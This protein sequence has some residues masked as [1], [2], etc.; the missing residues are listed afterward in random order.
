MEKHPERKISETGVMRADGSVTPFNAG[1]AVAAVV[2]MYGLPIPREFK[3]RIG[4]AAKELL[5]DGFDPNIVCAA[6][7]WAIKLARPHLVP[8]LALEMQSAQHGVLGTFPEYQGYLQALNRER[9]PELTAI[10]DALK[11]AFRNDPDGS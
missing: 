7:L 8:N 9:K 6:M 2:D 1:D 4:K 11:G 3:A 5:E 10:R